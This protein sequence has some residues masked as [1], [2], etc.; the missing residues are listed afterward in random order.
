[1]KKFLR[2]FALLLMF[3]PCAFIMTACGG[4]EYNRVENETNFK[5]AVEK[6]SSLGDNYTIT[7]S[8]RQTGMFADEVSTSSVANETIIKINGN[9]YSLIEGEDITYVID[10]INYVTTGD[11]SFDVSVASNISIPSFDLT[12][13]EDDDLQDIIDYAFS[14]NSEAI[15]TNGS[16][17]SITFS[18]AKYLNDILDIVAE[19]ESSQN[20]TLADLI[21]NILA[22]YE[23]T[24]PTIGESDA[25]VGQGQIENF[26][27]E[28][29][30]LTI[31]EIC[32]LIETHTGYDV[33]AAIKTAFATIQL[34]MI[35]D[36]DFVNSTH[37]STSLA[38]Q[39]ANADFAIDMINDYL[40]LSLSDIVEQVL[41]MVNPEIELGGVSCFAFVKEFLTNNSVSSLLA[42]SMAMG[43]EPT[44]EELLQAKQMLTIMLSTINFEEIDL[45]LTL[46][47]ENDKLTGANIEL[48]IEYERLGKEREGKMIYDFDF[49]DIGT[50]DVTLPEITSSTE[51]EATGVVVIKSS[52]IQNG[53]IKIENYQNEILN[54]FFDSGITLMA[55]DGVTELIKVEKEAGENEYT[56]TISAEIVAE[57]F[58]QNVDYNTARA[59]VTVGNSTLELALVVDND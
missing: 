44:N 25:V 32:D 19:T 50:T 4:N 57:L 10:G 42:Q 59:V 14:M 6:T 28:V 40:S 20:N 47:T 23:I 30:N 35:E 15:E 8:S 13:L 39:Y 18:F 33:V 21:N 52:M 55:D 43:E 51:I 53:E 7:T 5:A 16:D 45:M 17:V 54:A 41:V 3:V 2:M 46:T 36:E 27:D 58:A 49:T 26:L 56:I 38:V 29:D 1:M 9:N 22:H 48:D 12:Q 11:N 34:S 24:L 31:Q 37:T